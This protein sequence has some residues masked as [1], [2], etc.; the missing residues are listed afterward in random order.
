MHTIKCR[1]IQIE[2]ILEQGFIAE[3]ILVGGISPEKIGFA[4]QVQTD[5]TI[6]Q[7]PIH[8]VETSKT[9]G[10][11]R[12][13]FNTSALTDQ[14]RLVLTEQLAQ[15]NFF[16]ELSDDSV[17]KL[18]PNLKKLLV[19]IDESAFFESLAIIEMLSINNIE[20]IAYVKTE[21]PQREFVDYL[22]QKLPEG[23]YFLSSISSDEIH[24]IF[25]QQTMGTKLFLSGQWPMIDSLKEM[26]YAAGFSDEEIQYKGYGR[27]VEK[28]FCVKCY[29]FNRKKQTAETR[30]DR[31]NTVLDVSPHFSKRL[32]AYLGYIKVE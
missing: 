12:L 1:L 30:C 26:A 14:E 25:N 20:T 28:I 23:I 31:C 18:D 19:I 5:E 27:K 7:L 24:S 2:R 9:E 32:D 8:L 29:S 4:D 15:Q 11:Y 3:A 22:Q 10:I 13:L 21:E 17:F 6:F 16:L